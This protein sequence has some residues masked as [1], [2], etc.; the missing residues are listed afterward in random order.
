MQRN[1]CRVHELV[2]RRHLST[3]KIVDL[4]AGVLPVIS[5]ALPY[6]SSGSIAP[7]DV[8]ATRP[9]QSECTSSPNRSSEPSGPAPLV[10]F[11]GYTLSYCS[12]FND[13]SSRAGWDKFAGVPRGDPKGEKHE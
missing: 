6:L 11:S 4:G 7:S 10:T 5:L 13:R 8:A 1:T 9:A 12:D 3:V 2:L